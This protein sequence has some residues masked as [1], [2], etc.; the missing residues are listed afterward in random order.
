MAARSRPRRNIIFGLNP[1]CRAIQAR[2]GAGY[3][4]ISSSVPDAL[5]MRPPD[6][7]NSH[8]AW[9]PSTA[10]WV[11]QMRSRGTKPSTIVQADMQ[12]PSMTM[13]SPDSRTWRNRAV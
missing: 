11:A 9:N 7:L 8:A 4:F 3:V 6:L 10:L 1:P 5:A 12:V 2:T 13:D